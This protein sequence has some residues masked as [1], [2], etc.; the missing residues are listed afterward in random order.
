MWN[1]GQKLLK[2]STHN[3]KLQFCP[4]STSEVKEDDKDKNKIVETEKKKNK[5]ENDNDVEKVDKNKGLVVEL[6]FYEHY[7][8]PKLLMQFNDWM[9]FIKDDDV[10]TEIV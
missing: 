8:E 4:P 6:A 10:R 7:K 1:N 2:L 3:V 5:D 9:R